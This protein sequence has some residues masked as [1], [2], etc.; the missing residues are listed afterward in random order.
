MKG[1]KNRTLTWARKISEIAPPL[2][3]KESQRRLLRE[4]E[5]LMTT[6]KLRIVAWTLALGLTEPT[7]A[8]T[9]PVHAEAGAASS[10]ASSDDT[11]VALANGVMASFGSPQQ[12]AAAPSPNVAVD[13]RSGAEIYLP[14]GE[15]IDQV[16]EV[17]GRE[18]PVAVAS[19]KRNPVELGLGMWALSTGA[20]ALTRLGMLAFGLVLFTLGAKRWLRARESLLAAP[21]RSLGT[22]AL[23]MVTAF[24]AAILLTLT[25]VGIPLAL[26][27]GFVAWLGLYVGQLV[28][29]LS[30]GA[31]LPRSLRPRSDLGQVAVGAL[32]LWSIS[33]VPGFGFVALL[34][35]G[36]LGLGACMASRA[37]DTTAGFSGA[38]WGV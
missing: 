37:R 16:I 6:A 24:G 17:V 23:T 4:R 31:L 20:G 21:L 15:T 8:W 34:C 12:R 11:V 18:L 3:R 29:A 5:T 33:L 19:I 28:A 30:L 32:A 1:S 13:P 35:A 2:A 25:L 27:V 10:Q 26:F 14:T 38:T 9:T 22:G 7:A 36:L